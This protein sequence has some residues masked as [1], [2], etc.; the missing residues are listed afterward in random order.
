M[1]QVSKKSGGR[2]PSDLW[3]THIKKGKEISKGNYKEI[4]NYCPYSKYKGSPQDF[5]EHLANNCL[6]VPS[7]IRQTYLNKVLIDL[8]TLKNQLKKFIKQ[9]YLILM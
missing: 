8:K 6:N 7:N 4:C 1:S 3:N 9:K 2:P 5:E